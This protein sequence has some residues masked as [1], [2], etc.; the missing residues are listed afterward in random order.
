MSDQARAAG[1]P[2]Q[3]NSSAYVLLDVLLTPIELE[4]ALSSFP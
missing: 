1:P 4:L 3:N 2:S